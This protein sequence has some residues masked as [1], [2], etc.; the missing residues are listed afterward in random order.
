MKRIIDALASFKLTIF[1]LAGMFVLT[2]I[3]TIV[4]ETTMSLYE[5]QKVYFDSWFVIQPV[6]GLDG[7][8]VPLPGGVLLM[9]L[10]SVNLLVGGI[11]RLRRQL[12][13]I[14]ILITHIGIAMLM[15]SGLVSLMVAEH[16]LLGAYE[17]DEAVEYAD[18]H[19]LEVVAFEVLDD[20]YVK[21]YLLPGD[22]FIGLR[23]GEKVT[24]RH[25][26]LPF[27]LDV[28][29][30]IL[31]ASPRR[32]GPMFNV[33]VPVVEGYY[34]HQREPAIGSREVNLSG[35]YATARVDGKAPQTGILWATDNKPVRETD[36]WTFEADGKQWG[37]KLR[38]EVRELPFKIR[39][40]DFDMAFHPG[41]RRPE[42]FQSDIT[43]W[44][45]D[46]EA[47][48]RIEMNKPLRKSGHI[49]FQTNWGPQND[50]HATK[51]YTVFEIVTNPAD[52]W[53]AWS[54]YV[55]A[56]GLLIHFSRMLFRYVRTE[57]MVQK[58]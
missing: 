48:Q 29:D 24:M 11:L 36:P 38:K 47:T 46:A 37:V 20:G 26:D 28:H 57:Q 31:N 14:G 51:H 41:T 18:A 6:P 42:F 45:G 16:G 9:T 19:H 25:P 2:W 17:G 13:R 21:E 7:I 12:S 32:K 1:V 44:D 30:F 39:V 43:I 10:L 40:D 3:G 49:L 50:P 53:P 54:C 55:I 15:A 27:E 56:I 33:S 52:Q 8:N 34:L 4:Q 22:E 35:C 5:T 23:T 58:A